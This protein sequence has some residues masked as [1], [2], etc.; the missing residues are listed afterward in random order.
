MMDTAEVQHALE[1][2]SER[3]SWETYWNNDG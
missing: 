1:L 3:T 2:N